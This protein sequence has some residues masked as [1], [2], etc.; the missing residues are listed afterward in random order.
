MR[1]ASASEDTS[2]Q[3]WDA[4]NRNNLFLYKGHSATVLAIDWSP[5]GDYIASAS[6]DHTVQVWNPT[7]TSNY[8][9][10]YIGHKD[11]VTDVAWSPDGK[12]I[13]STGEDNT[14]IVWDTTGKIQHTLVHDDNA[15]MIVSSL[16]WSHDS[17]YIVTGDYN[18]K[19]SSVKIWN[20][21]KESYIQIFKGTS[22]QQI[23]TVAWSPNSKYIAAGGLDTQVR[24]WDA[25]TGE[26]VPTHTSHNQPIMSVQWSHD[27][28]NIVSSSFDK[29]VQIWTMPD[30]VTR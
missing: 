5:L 29:T 30:V 15:M 25:A 23:Y 6:E 3:V 8:Q 22:G 19:Y 7:L 24:I 16:A 11:I 12:Y 2:V 18:D 1:I 4:T 10:T 28:K 14:T 21:S 26:L 27:S 9:F 13:A 17:N 20:V